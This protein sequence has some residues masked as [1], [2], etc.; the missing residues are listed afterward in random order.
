MVKKRNSAGNRKGG[1]RFA[2]ICIVEK[3]KFIF[4][5]TKKNL[6]GYFGTFFLKKRLKKEEEKNPGLPC[7]HVC[8]G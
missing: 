7:E 8:T 3:R 5:I 6:W 2:V 1:R 4:Q